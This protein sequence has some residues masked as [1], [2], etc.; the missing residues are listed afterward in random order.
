MI[1]MMAQVLVI[2]EFAQESFTWGKAVLSDPEVSA[3]PKGAGDMVDYIRGDESPHVQYLMTALSEIRARALK[4]MDGKTMP[5]QVVVDGMLHNMLKGL[6]KNRPQQ[7]RDDIRGS[8]LD[9]LKKDGAND[10]LLE[11]YDSLQPDW[12]APELTGFE[13]A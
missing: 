3:D 11:E 12:D 8:V 10:S 6:T 13:A 2:E 5:G 9:A 7:Q 1:Q 4:T